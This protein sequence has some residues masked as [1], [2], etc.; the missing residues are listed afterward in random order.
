MSFGP[1]I[2]CTTAYNLERDQALFDVQQMV[3]NGYQVTIRLRDEQEVTR[4]RW[5]SIKKH[6]PPADITRWALP[7]IF[8]PTD[9]QLE[10]VG[11]REQVDCIFHTAMKDWNDEGF[12]LENLQALDMI[13]ST[14]I[15]RG[16]TYEFRQKSLFDPYHDSYLYVILGVNRK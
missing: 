3:R 15:I 9:K 6:N 7:V 4:D 1:P 13:R 12:T 11:I 8:S 16:A 2:E 5:N 14:I 10:R